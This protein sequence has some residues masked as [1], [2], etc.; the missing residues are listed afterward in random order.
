MQRLVITPEQFGDASIVNLTNE[1]RH[2]LLSVLRL[3]PGDRL[4]VLDGCGKGWLAALTSEETLNLL[5]PYIFKTELSRPIHLVAALPKS[6]FDE[7]V[8]C[9]TELGVTRITPIISARTILKPSAN[10][11][12]RW[13]KIATEAAEQSERAFVPKIL[14]PLKFTDYLDSLEHPHYLCA[15]RAKSKHLLD[16][17]VASPP[18]K[19]SS[20]LSFCIGPE[21]GW[22]DKEIEQAIAQ[23]METVSLGRSILRAVT[24]AITTISIAN[25]TLS[26]ERLYKGAEDF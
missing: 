2:Y 8:R 24:A 4:I 21:G 12:K 14:T 22:T 16:V 1:Q 9:C 26:T 3:R 6:G 10:K 23:G 15:A 25:A 19:H 20:K 7:V 13:Q 11:L 5:E 18:S 17:L